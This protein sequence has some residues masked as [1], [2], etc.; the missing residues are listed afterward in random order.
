M[1]RYLRLLRSA[2]LIALLVAMLSGSLVEAAGPATSSDLEKAVGREDF[3]EARRIA[4]AILQAGTQPDRQKA[5]SLYGRIL[6]ATKDKETARRY[7][8]AAGKANQGV[9]VDPQLLAI[10]RI[11]L[12]ALDGK[13]ESAIASLEKMLEQ[14]GDSPSET[15]AE[16]ADIAALLNLEAGNTEKAQKAV[17]LGTRILVYRGIATGYLPTL[18]KNRMTTPAQQLFNKAEALRKAGKF[19]EAIP[20]YRQVQTKFPKD[21]LV[22]PSG[23]YIGHCMWRMDRAEDAASHWKRF[24]E[25]A[26]SGPWRAQARIAMVDLALQTQLDLTRASEHAMAAMATLSKGLDAQAEPSWKEAS[27]DIYVRQGVVA[28][29]DHRYEAAEDAFS[30]AKLVT[31]GQGAAAKPLSPE[32]QAGLDRLIEAAQKKSA[33]VPEEFDGLGDPKAVTALALGGLFHV[34]H[35]YDLAQEYFALPLTGSLWSRTSAHR[36]FAGMGLA[37]AIAASERSGGKAVS[38]SLLD[39]LRI[40]G[41][42]QSG[43]PKRT[44]T[45]GPGPFSNVEFLCKASLAEYPRG[46]WH[47]ETLFCLATA[48]ENHAE[49]TAA[50]PPQKPAAAKAKPEPAAP[51]AAD[52]VHAVATEAKAQKDRLAALMKLK[53]E[54]LPYYEE[55]LTKYPKSP[56]REAASYH[57][58]LLRCGLAEVA[59]PAKEEALWQEADA[60]LRHF[61]KE[62]PKS[63]L[64]GDVFVRRID[65]ALEHTFDV[66]AA[67]KVIDRGIAW[68]KEQKV[69]VVTTADGRVTAQSLADAAKAIRSGPSCLDHKT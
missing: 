29:V 55:L 4:D 41:K 49:A 65:I 23:F 15:L 19:N 8:E 45:P 43:T 9:S 30:K 38:G 24:I 33:L 6:L 44:G 54:A 27:F 37:R 31:N 26:I 28:L 62:F 3:V 12:S 52:P 5:L 39:K 67:A 17:D 18:L 32:V 58:A 11:W 64:A 40:G 53:Q 47:D 59:T 20:V 68:A 57:A 36:S 22:H 14:A 51:R 42:P 2:L 16:A 48:I 63:P 10:Y 34:L 25:T 46:S 35:Q 61:T 50:K 60:A 21:L 56:H 13:R 69:E 7:L 66:S 1:A